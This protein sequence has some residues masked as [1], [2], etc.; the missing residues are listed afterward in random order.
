MNLIVRY[1][2]AKEAQENMRPG[3]VV[4][5]FEAQFLLHDYVNN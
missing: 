2:E 1:K 5:S 4:K 3:D